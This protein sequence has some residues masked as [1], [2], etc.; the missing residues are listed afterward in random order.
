[1]EDVDYFFFAAFAFLIAA[2]AARSFT[3]RAVRLRFAMAARAFSPLLWDIRSSSGTVARYDAWMNDLDGDG[4]ALAGLSLA[5]D[6]CE[7]LASSLPALA[8]AGRGGVRNLI[9]H[10]AVA[11]LLRHKKL[12][13]CLW[14]AIGRDLAA[15]KATL[16]DKTPESNWHAAWHQDRVISVKERLDVGGYVAW[17]MKS[18]TLQ[19]EPPAEV[20]AQMLAVRIHLDDAGADNGPLQ[21]IPGS[22][23]LGKLSE[24]QLP[25]VV[26]SR[27]HVEVSVP[28]GG[29]LLMRPLLIHASPAAAS[30]AHRRVLHIEFAPIDAISPLF[31]HAAV[32]LHR[33]A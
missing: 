2:R 32:P 12:A 11:E 6:Q 5:A 3:R 9:F 4:Y 1:V 21:V 10:P 28:R 8:S 7:Y 26:A 25:R 30:P 17:R 31:W 22:H 20:L 27:P 16:F 24:A 23:R 33:A 29:F 13:A 14:S 18:G 15:V 19:V